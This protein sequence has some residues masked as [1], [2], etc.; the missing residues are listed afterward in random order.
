[1]I[2]YTIWRK[3]TMTTRDKE[4]NGSTEL[5]AKAMR[6][7]FEEAHEPV[8]S[9]IGEAEERLE[10]NLGDKIDNL[11]GAVEGMREQM[12]GMSKKIDRLQASK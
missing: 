2:L 8:V 11:D 9:M 6:K 7:V 3:Y 4:L 5:L 12:N 1:M 10:K